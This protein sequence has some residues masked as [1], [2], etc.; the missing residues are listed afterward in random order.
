V[1]GPARAQALA[2]AADDEAL[3]PSQ[4]GQPGL[5]SAN[6]INRWGLSILLSRR[7]AKKSM[8]LS[9]PDTNFE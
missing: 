5:A 8:F 9:L 1:P 6:A 7:S 3:V 4:T 2:S